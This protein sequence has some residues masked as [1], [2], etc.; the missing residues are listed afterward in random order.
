M[1][2]KQLIVRKMKAGE[3]KDVLRVGRKAFE[4]I[5]ALFLSKAKDAVVAILDG[6]IVG[7]IQYKA[8]NTSQK[9]IVYIDGAFV[10]P[11]YHGMGIGKKLYHETFRILQKEGYEAITALVK[12]DN[13][14][15]WKLFLDNGFKR[16]SFKEIINQLGLMGTIK[17]YVQTPYCIGLGMDFYLWGKAEKSQEKAKSMSPV[18]AFFLCNLLFAFPMWIN[19]WAE[20]P[21][22]LG[23][24]LP[25][26][27]MM[28]ML[29]ILPRYIGALC[30]KKPWHFQFNNAGSLLP[31]ILGIWNSVFP[32]NMNWNP[33]TYEN[34]DQFRKYLAMPELAKWGIFSL[35][36]LLSLLEQPFCK[37]LG[38]MSYAHLI[39]ASIPLYPFECYGAGRI[40]RYSKKLW[41]TTCIITVIEVFLVL[42]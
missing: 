34:T 21:K 11:D 35:L 14:G 27:I 13:V 9:K 2:N 10:D 40:Y 29:Y 25:A 31:I 20:T 19:L 26:Y 3:E 37:I 6:K 7:G 1:D 42:G 28:L 8:L 12:N 23:L 17:Q 24:F 38:A 16:A 22:Q 36:A 33:D 39:Y 32:M 5:E 18:L 15:S 41:L 4:I 30:Y